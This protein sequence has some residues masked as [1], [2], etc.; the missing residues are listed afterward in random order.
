MPFADFLSVYARDINHSSLERISLFYRFFI[1]LCLLIICSASITKKMLTII[2]SLFIF[3]S[4]FIGK[5]IYSMYDETLLLESILLFIKFYMFFLFFEGFTSIQKN[6]VINI[7]HIFIFFNALILI[8]VAPIILGSLFNI[9]LFKYYDSERWGVKGIIVS[10]NEAS[11]FLLSSLTWFFLNK[12]SFFNSICILVVMSAMI[13]SGTKASILG[14]LMLTL[15]A[16]WSKNPISFIYKGTIFVLIFI[17]ITFLLYNYNISFQDAV[18]KTFSYFEYQYYHFANGSLVSLALSGRDIKLYT[19]YSSIL[20]NEILS[21]IIGGYPIAGYTVEM[22]VFDLIPLVGFF[23]TIFYFFIWFSYWNKKSTN[24][25]IYQKRLKRVF[26]FVF[27][28]LAFFGGHMFS[29]AVAAPFIALLSIKF[30]Q[31]TNTKVA[32]SALFSPAE[33]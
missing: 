13:L 25:K 16:L 31:T 8:Y 2:I 32:C 6:N 4:V 23:G 12:K 20:E 30:I 27:I 14:L 7:T 29:S 33:N 9:E 21:L 19:V 11:A 22:D 26:L 18:L 17:A 1:F 3:I 28:F 24:L 15:G 5:Y 10:G